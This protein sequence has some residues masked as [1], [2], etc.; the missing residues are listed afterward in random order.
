MFNDL[1][2]ILTYS[3]R[4]LKKQSRIL[5]QA[6]FLKAL[7]FPIGLSII[8]ITKITLDKGIL[9]KDLGIFLK[10]S[11]LGFTAFL[12]SRTLQYITDKLML[13]ARANFSLDVNYDM[14]KRLF[15]LDYLK[16][17]ELSSAENSFILDYDYGTIESLT[18]DEIPSLASLAKIPVFFVLSFLLSPLLTLLVFLAFPFMALHTAWSSRKRKKYRAS[19]L[20]HIRKHSSLM[21]DLL[22]NVKLVKSFFKENW[23]LERVISMF[24][25]KT[26]ASRKSSSFYYKAR[27]VSDLFTKVSTVIFWLLGGY[28]IIKG[29]LTFGAFSA[30]SMYTA[31]IISEAGNL[32]GFIQELN[33]ERLSIKRNAEFI[34]EVSE[35]TRELYTLD[36]AKRPVFDRDIEFKEITFGYAKSKPLFE[37]LSFIIPTGKWTLIK[38][39]SGIGK[40][41]LLS[42]FLRLFRPASGGIY[43]GGNDIKR[44][45]RTLFS[46]NISV[47]HQEP[48]LFNDSLINN[49][50]LGDKKETEIIEKLLY[51]TRLDELVGNLPMGYNSRVGESGFSLSGGQ[52]QRIAIARALARE[53][54]I[55]ILDEATSFIDSGMEQEI[56]ENIKKLFPSITVM[57]VT[58]RETAWDFAD[59]T[60]T[61]K[62]RK[63]CKE[64][65]IT[66]N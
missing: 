61:L 44:I 48:Y 4:I 49:I 43:V 59:E 64:S 21:H 47:V 45:D 58:H 9:G 3:A 8:Y 28:L 16:I 39:T 56:F 62:D 63:I 54:K 30:V 13:R 29:S 65:K 38:G 26:E 15:G 57:F 66:V 32:S 37:G 34:K 11:A 6:S 46:R 41:S 20:Y 5:Y 17:K 12:F 36:T 53:P 18:F 50:L 25:E 60:F 2:T 52:K 22:L 42:L 55:L 35:G 33:G 10:F 27:F 1:K 7:S 23:A 31:M 19:E 40:T 14:T 51:C 24:R